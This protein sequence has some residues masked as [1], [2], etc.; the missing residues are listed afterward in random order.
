MLLINCKLYFA[1]YFS[2]ENKE[3]S[4]KNENC[5]FKEIEKE[6]RGDSLEPVIKNGQK[7]KILDGYYNCN[8]VNR[9]DTIIYK[10]GEDLLIKIVK[11]L[12]GDK[13]KLVKNNKNNNEW[14]ILINGEILKNSEGKNYKVDQIGYNILSL[15]IND[16]G[17]VIPA[18]SYLILSNNPEMAVDSRRFGFVGKIDFI[19]KVVKN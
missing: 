11:G 8:N 15:Y 14:N 13:I 7:I 3:S 19:G 17:G 10:Y 2:L 18:E 12:P 6:I 5:D 9:D 1:K 16:Y 4:L